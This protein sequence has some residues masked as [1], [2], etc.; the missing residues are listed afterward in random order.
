[1]A[2][3][4]FPTCCVYEIMLNFLPFGAMKLWK[5]IYQHFPDSMCALHLDIK[6]LVQYNLYVSTIITDRMTEVIYDFKVWI[7]YMTNN[8]GV[9]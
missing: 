4:S 6:V 5:G 3:D 9:K 1:M 2:L 8:G 7:A